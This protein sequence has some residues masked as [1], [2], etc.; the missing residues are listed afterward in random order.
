MQILLLFNANLL[1]QNR[2]AMVKH[3]KFPDIFTGS[4]HYPSGPGIES[5][6]RNNQR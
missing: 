5:R 3:H 2:I 1:F 4:H 6:Q